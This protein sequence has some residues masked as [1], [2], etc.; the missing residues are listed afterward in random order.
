MELKAGERKTVTIPLSHDQLAYYNES[1]HTFDV[2]AGTVNV[3]VSASSAD[4]RLTGTLNAE[5]AVVKTTYLTKD[6][7]A[8]IVTPTVGTS[9]NTAAVY[10]L[11]GRRMTAMTLKP[12][13]YIMGHQK[14]YVK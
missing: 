6:D 7:S 12:G 8:A 9:G 3:Y 14:V 13:L 11:Q 5:G 4:D 1:T 2:E 10:D